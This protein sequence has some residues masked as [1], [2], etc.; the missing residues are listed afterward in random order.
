[1]TATVESQP[2]DFS[3]VLDLVK[4][5]SFQDTLAGHETTTNGDKDGHTHPRLDEEERDSSTERKDF[6]VANTALG[7]FSQI[8][9][10]LGAPVSSPALAVQP[11]QSD[12]ST[13]RIFT[14]KT[15]YT[16]D[17]AAH[18]TPSTTPKRSVHWQN[19]SDTDEH[20]EEAVSDSSVIPDS[21]TLSKSQRKKRNRRER[22][23]KEAEEAER[24]LKKS[25][26]V[27]ESEADF[28]SRKAPA[29]KASLHA[30]DTAPR[31]VYNLRER[32]ASGQAIIPPTPDSLQEAA[33]IA[34]AS[35][36]AALQA[37]NAANTTPQKENTLTQQASGQRTIPA[38]HHSYST[39][40]TVPF[41]N[42][43]SAAVPSQA[44][45]STPSGNVSDTAALQFLPA[46][47][48]PSHKTRATHV[49]P[50]L[51]GTPGPA[52]LPPK[53]THI[54]QPMVVRSGEDRHWALLMKLIGDFYE[55]RKHLVS[56][57]NLTTH[58]NDPNGIHVFVDASNIFIGFKDQ[59]KRSR[60]IPPWIQVP[61][62]DLSFDALALLM[63]RRRPVAKRVLAGSTP[64]LPPFDKAKAVGY[65][66]SILEKVYKAREL[67]DR[68][69]YF[70]EI[71]RQKR[72]SVRKG[73]RAPP[74]NTVAAVNGGPAGGNRS[75]SETNTPQYAPARMIEQGVDEILHLKILESVIDAEK[76]ATIVLATGD[77]AQAE[78][79]QGFMK[80]TERALKKGWT[81]ELVSWSKNISAMY[82][83]REW[84]E[85]WGPRFKIVTLDDYAEEL[86]DM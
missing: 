74:A 79:S 54:I 26:T 45:I 28:V 50:Q 13:P 7:D 34:M 11:A 44:L 49:A 19:L 75:G 71:D 85:A 18:F 65:E 12:G 55:D 42:S 27:S 73:A 57:M 16:S 39:Q 47:V 35:M 67:T 84:R 1:M 80:M 31:K 63:E 15:D 21:P 52:S 46:T 17:G 25:A 37:H 58:N 3:H 59:L 40:P 62:V 60:G 78:Y 76:P 36:E 24:R 86:L 83:R 51:A 14:T 23:A 10:Y 69:V 81:V 64:W 70:K 43:G 48:G 6:A 38:R 20:G 29:K 56:P 77:A 32:D 41:S 8:F 9:K 2:W 30:V 4:S 33:K 61:E 68:Q 53:P 22:R 5:L 82:T 66:C 72:H